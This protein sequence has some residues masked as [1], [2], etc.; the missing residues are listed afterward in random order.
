MDLNQRKLTAIEWN[1]IEVPTSL[2][3]QWIGDLIQD[4]Y[5]NVM[6][7]RNETASL[8]QHLKVTDSDDIDRF[9]F[10]RYL[11]SDMKN[12]LKYAKTSPITF[13]CIKNTEKLIKKADLIRFNNT[14]SVIE[15]MKST[16]YEFV[17]LSILKTTLK[18]REKRNKAWVMGYYT[19]VTLLGYSVSS[20]N[21]T[22]Y[23]KLNEIL[24]TLANEDDTN[25]SELVYRAAELIEYN[26]YLLKY[27]D[28]ELYD[29]QRR[30]FTQFKNAKTPQLVL[31]IAPTGTGKTMSPLGLA[32][33][34]KII[35]VC[36]ARHVG[37]AL[38]KAAITMRRKVAFAF[39]CVDAQGIRLHY[40]AAKEFTR[41]RRSGAIRKVDNSVGDD[42]EIIISDL[43]SYLSAMHYMCAFNKKEEIITYWD[44]PTI[45]LDYHDHDCHKI[46]QQNWSE[47]L[48]P[49]MVLSSATLPQQE[50]L[51]PTIQDFQ[52]RFDDAEVTSIVS[53]D[54]KKTIPLVNKAGYVEMPH[55]MYE[56][57]Q[58]VKTCAEYVVKNKTLLRY[59][60]LDGCVELIKIVTKKY[61]NAIAD[62]YSIGRQFQTV[63]NVN[64]L[65][66]KSYYLKI[67]SN[68]DP[69]IWKQIRD[70]IMSKRKKKHQS[71]IYVN[72][73][74][75]HTLTDG[76]TIFL[77]ADPN[78]IGLFCMQQA[79]IP[80]KVLTEIMSAIDYNAVV[81][82]KIATLT[83][84][85][86]DLQAKDEAAGN[87]KKLSDV[88]RGSPEVKALRKDIDELKKC[89]MTVQL[90]DKYIPN[91]SDHLKRFAP[92]IDSSR[93]F[94]PK[95]T[96]NEV[97]KIM[98][99]DDIEDHWKLLLMM[100][101][102]VFAEHNSDRYME[103]MKQLAMNQKLYL[104]IASTDFI[105]GTN[106]QFCHGYLSSDLKRM[107]QEKAIQ[108]MGRVGRNKLQF[109]YSLRF[110]ND[111]IL[112]SL[113]EHDADK[114]EVAN[115]AR[116][117]NS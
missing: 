74:D 32:K 85:L 30:L 31:Y 35:F 89:I 33:G 39:G 8:L 11:Q 25:P 115:M 64:M 109:D 80:D 13:I 70:E 95:I 107:S 38:A 37:L 92:D 12:I 56:D 20:C 40:G 63:E 98:L 75:A 113:F 116:L 87:D 104:I 110:R 100:G 46:I 69:A 106:Y 5:N 114:P 54:C 43:K 55:H 97:E 61:P 108:A 41:D 18:A 62:R 117:F 72:T 105:Y 26:P 112:K 10:A 79:Q 27:A 103:I 82:G 50:E 28:A 60:D 76:P 4:G 2:E 94:K 96:E 90:P 17:L 102:G 84:T 86:E 77:S 101:I 83:K 78:K 66:V 49:N 59:L 44:E 51:A 1:S 23:T 15:N 57:Y 6:L 47:N 65:S 68:I 71:N 81:N 7:K 42:V 21:R 93:V 45:T 99:I 91:M 73:C 16:L 3:E 19:M 67:L 34:Y 24:S 52:S 29:H 111:D 22:L 48:I 14:D 9:V 88:N 58:D 36:A 53:Y